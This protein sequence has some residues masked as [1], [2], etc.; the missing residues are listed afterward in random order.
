MTHTQTPTIVPTPHTRRWTS[1][2]TTLEYTTY[3]GHPAIQ[4]TTHITT[5]DWAFSRVTTMTH[6]LWV[7][8]PNTCTLT[9]H[10]SPTAARDIPLPFLP[11]YVQAQETTLD[12]S[13]LLAMYAPQLL[14]EIENS[15][16][17]TLQESIMAYLA[18]AQH[19]PPT[20]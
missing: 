4:A 2:A 6:V 10:H 20:N 11:E 5:Y 15:L 12:P 3:N 18:A 1:H 13:L 14:S 9:A 8:A 19:T 17:A 16:R 7:S